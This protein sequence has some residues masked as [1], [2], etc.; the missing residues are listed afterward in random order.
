[1]DTILIYTTTLGKCQEQQFQTAN[2]KPGGVNGTIG[3]INTGM[4]RARLAKT[5]PANYSEC[6]DG[7]RDLGILDDDLVKR[8]IPMARFRNSLVHHYRDIDP[9]QV[10]DYAQNN[11]GDFEDYS[12]AILRYLT[13]KSPSN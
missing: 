11:W 12:Q 8:L 5:G 7:L 4:V 6:F 13:S 1:M 3:D 2:G 10:L 9:H